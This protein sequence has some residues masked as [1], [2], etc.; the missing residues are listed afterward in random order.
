MIETPVDCLGEGD[1]ALWI[2]SIGGL[3]KAVIVSNKRPD[4]LEI[5]SD[6]GLNIHVYSPVHD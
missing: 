6:M 4:V 3:P 2:N 5:V 1:M